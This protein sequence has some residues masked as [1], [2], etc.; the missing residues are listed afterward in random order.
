MTLG[1]NDNGCSGD[2]DDDELESIQLAEAEKRKHNAELKSGRGKYDVYA[3]EMEN[4]DVLTKYDDDFYKPKRKTF[5][6]NER[7][8]GVEDEKQKL[9]NIQKNLELQ[10]RELAKIEGPKVLTSSV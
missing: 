3:E 2:S 7:G 5:Y 6:L 9:A 10:Q 1:L 4:N 8:L